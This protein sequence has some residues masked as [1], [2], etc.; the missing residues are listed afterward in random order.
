M[1]AYTRTEGS[2]PSLSAIQNQIMISFQNII[3]SILKYLPKKLLKS[4]AGKSVIIDGN[5]LDIN[6]QIISKLAQP[7]ID[8]YKS[9]VQEYRRGAKLLSNL[10]LPIC[11]GVSIED[12]TFR[13]NSNELKARIYTSKTCTDMAPV[14]LFFHQGGMVIMDHLTDNYFCSLLSKECNA[15]VIS[16]DYRRCP[17]VNFPTPI[18]DSLAL[19][20]FVQEHSKILGIDNKKV[21]L[22]GDS[23]GGMI[24]ATMSLLIRDRGGIQPAGLLLAYPWISTKKENQPSLSSCAETFPL[25][26]ETIDFF[27]LNVFPNGKNIDHPWANPLEQNLKNLPPS[28][29]AIAGFDPI[30]DQGKLFAQTLKE[31]GNSVIYHFFPDLC[32]SFLLLSRISKAAENACILIA[33]ETSKILES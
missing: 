2:N 18:E 8:K 15:K 6:L 20:D 24:S 17:E 10:D 9:D 22:A 19:W 16:L 21:M 27:E 31:S 14:I 13:L 11:K 26:K 5:E 30:R 32:H 1:R 3:V 29:V 33:K 4:L 23:A 12:R 28:I 25:T 7:N